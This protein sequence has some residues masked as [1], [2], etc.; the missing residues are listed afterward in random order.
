[1]VKC[2][3]ACSVKQNFASSSKV[4]NRKKQ[5]DF[6]CLNINQLGDEADDLYCS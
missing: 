3:G 6:S 1:M 2:E 4:R 5:S